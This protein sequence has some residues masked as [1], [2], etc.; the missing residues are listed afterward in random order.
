MAEKAGLVVCVC[1][2]M[3]EL[4]ES[5]PDPNQ[6]DANGKKLSKEASLH[7]GKCRV[8][9]NMCERNFCSKCKEYPYHIGYTCE[10]YKFYKTSM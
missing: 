1:G 7:M 3:F 5:K 2:N 9:C 8:R 6:K 4:V 10:G